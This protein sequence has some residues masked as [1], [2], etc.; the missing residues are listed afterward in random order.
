MPYINVIFDNRPQNINTNSDL[1]LFLFIILF[2]IAL[3]EI[4]Y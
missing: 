2:I 1:K 3:Q 4:I